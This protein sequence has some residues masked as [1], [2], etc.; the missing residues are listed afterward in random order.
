MCLHRITF[1]P[2]HLSRCKEGK[3]IITLPSGEAF[4]SFSIPLSVSIFVKLR[5]PTPFYR[6]VR[7][8][9]PPIRCLSLP[10]TL[11]Q[12]LDARLPCR[13]T[14]ASVRCSFL[15]AVSV[16]ASEHT[17]LTGQ[18]SEG[19]CFPSF[20][21]SGTAHQALGFS[22][23]PSR[24]CSFH[25]H[26]TAPHDVAFDSTQKSFPSPSRCNP[27]SVIWVFKFK[28]FFVR[29]LWSISLL[30]LF[31]PPVRPY[32]VASP[33]PLF[34]SFFFSSPISFPIS[35]DERVLLCEEL[36]RERRGSST[37]IPLLY[38]HFP[39]FQSAPPINSDPSI[40]FGALVA[41]TVFHQF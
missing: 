2:P 30:V 36:N 33:S 19:S 18:P 27:V 26:S 11:P 8:L 21:L 34:K 41:D 35:V 13:E 39:L 23:S 7:S 28:C 9:V 15:F 25:D 4:L 1:S 31:H 37:S 20:L 38:F 12:T 6:D 14:M 17:A 10:L 24:G 3:E 32:A 29:L 5:Y 22:P 16:F 40:C